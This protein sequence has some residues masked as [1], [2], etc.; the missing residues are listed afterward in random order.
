MPGELQLELIDLQCDTAMKDTKDKFA[1]MDINTFHKYLVPKYPR[2][3]A[4]AAKVLCMFGT[5]Y[6]CE[7]VFSIIILLQM[8]NNKTK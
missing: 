2:L 6:L 8:N 4:M 5:T 3:T 1:S 7:Q